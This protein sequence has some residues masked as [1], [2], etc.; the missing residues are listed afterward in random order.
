LSVP[1]TLLKCD[2]DSRM[3]QLSRNSAVAAICTPRDLRATV[4]E[5]PGLRYTPLSPV[6]LMMPVSAPTISCGSLGDSAMKYETEP[7]TVRRTLVNFTPTSPPVPRELP[8][9]SP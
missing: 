3:R 2:A 9:A 7:E 6:G 8:W 1:T 5:L 4:I